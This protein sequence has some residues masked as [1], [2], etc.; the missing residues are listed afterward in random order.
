MA[1]YDKEYWCSTATFV[2]VFGIME[3]E[4]YGGIGSRHIHWTDEVHFKSNMRS[5]Y[6]SWSSDDTYNP[7]V[8]SII[9]WVVIRR[10]QPHF[11]DLIMHCL[12]LSTSTWRF[13]FFPMNTS[14]LIRS[15]SC[16]HA[17]SCWPSNT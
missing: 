1:S 5:C 7:R 10:R 11:Y 6:C 3:H 9:L 4:V 2:C 17:R 8:T 16:P 14:L 15:S 12:K 13:R